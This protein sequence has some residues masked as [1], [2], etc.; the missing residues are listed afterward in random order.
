MFKLDSFDGYTSN[1]AGVGGKVTM[2]VRFVARKVDGLEIISGGGEE[3]IY[4]GSFT[5]ILRGVIINDTGTRGRM[6]FENGIEVIYDP[7]NL[8]ELKD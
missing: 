1:G 7:E 6:F 3:E 5:G 4:D 2:R 8:P